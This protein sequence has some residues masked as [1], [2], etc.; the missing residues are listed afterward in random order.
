MAIDLTTGKHQ[1]DES[2][3]YSGDAGFAMR[4][5]LAQKL[6]GAQPDHEA[7][8][9]LQEE[10]DSG[11]TSMADVGLAVMAWK[12]WNGI[13]ADLGNPKVEIQDKLRVKASYAAK[14]EANRL[15]EEAAR[16]AAAAQEEQRR[17]K[18]AA[19]AEEF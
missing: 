13:K 12:I 7:E 11:E 17:Q 1:I 18:E 5:L 19:R 15:A 9:D 8:A 6:P 3:M 2:G 14:A 4:R 16:R 10:V